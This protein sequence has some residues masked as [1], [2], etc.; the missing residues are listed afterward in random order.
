L[1]GSA[2]EFG[3]ETEI[4]RTEKNTKGLFIFCWSKI[5]AH[6][7]S[8]CRCIYSGGK[9]IKASLEKQKRKLLFLMLNI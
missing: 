6:D 2:I 3:N 8:T 9:G 7:M 5:L 1:S 4:R